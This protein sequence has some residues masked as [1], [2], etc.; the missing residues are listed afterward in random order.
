MNTSYRLEQA[1]KKLY[2]A[3]HANTL[4]PE[5]CQQC[6]VGNIL[7]NTDAWKHLSDQ[8]GSSRLNYVGIVHQNLGRK[9]NG[10]SPLELLN[11]EATFLRA[12]GYSLPLQKHGKKPKKPQDKH[13]LFEGLSATISYLCAL[14]GVENVMDY[15]KLFER[16]NGQP[17]H[18]LDEILA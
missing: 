8:H 11:I 13:L 15:S 9:F 7:D 14:D 10:Y 18:Q 1:I 17:C 16:K 12:C 3:F 6:A 5:C 2:T 4:H